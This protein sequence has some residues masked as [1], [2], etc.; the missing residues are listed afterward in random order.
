MELPDWNAANVFVEIVRHGSLTGAARQLGLP[1]STV[2]RKLSE[3]EARLGAKLV[4]RTTRS[5]SLTDV[6]L[7][8]FERAS[9]AAQDLAEAEQVVI[10]S[11]EQPR[12]VLRVTAPSDMGPLL[13]WIVTEF[14]ESHPHVD[15]YLDLSNRYVDLIAEGY[16]LALRGGKLE[17]S[18]YI[19][20]PVFHATFEIYASPSY[21]ERAGR[22][23]HVEELA[24]HS[25][26]LFGTEPTATWTLAAGDEVVRVPVRGRFLARD[27]ATLRQ[28]ALTGFGIALLPNFLSGPDLHH[29][30]LERVLA[31][32]AS[33]SAAG[34]SG[35]HLVYPSR[36]LLPAK[37]R[38]FITHLERSLA[39]WE[40]R[41]AA[42][43]STGSCSPSVAP[44]RPE[45]RAAPSE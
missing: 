14:L 30:R 41:C 26:L 32:F 18:S 20:R 8:Y 11:Q 42:V 12:G 36:E 13:T 17:D 43:R 33:R 21:L 16:D 9:R 34:P 23:Q 6:G 24:A 15:V 22:P 3:L 5:L 39:Q 44:L 45:P 1:K 7:A 25:C 40:D 19:A 29:G 4:Q 10:D 28:A 31:P 35:L 27:F 37:T 2:S 38:A